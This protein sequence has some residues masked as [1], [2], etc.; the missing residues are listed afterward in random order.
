MNKIRKNFL[1]GFVALLPIFATI[2]VIALVY[3][4]V[5]GIVSLIVPTEEITKIFIFIHEDFNT[6]KEL[7]A[8][9]IP[10]ISIILIVI[11]IYFIGFGLNNFVS[12]STIH[13]FEGIIAKIPFANSIYGSFK[14]VIELAVSN[15]NDVYRKTVLIEY[16][17]KGI[18]CMALVTNENNK[19]AEKYIGQGEMYNVF[20]PTSPNPT[21]GFYL[22]VKKDECIDLNITVEETFKSIIAGGA[23]NPKIKTG[24]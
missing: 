2:Y 20:V 6:M 8:I 19:N 3:K 10:L 11:K 13:F 1:T 7:L 15:K 22:I 4:F 14:Q 23:I 12:K 9:I 21:S 17:K 16:P 18:Y 24:E 5:V